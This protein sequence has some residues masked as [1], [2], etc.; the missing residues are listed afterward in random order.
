MKR[1][2]SL[3]DV[4]AVS[5]AALVAAQLL[6]A[7]TAHASCPFPTTD[8]CAEANDGFGHP[9]A[10][11][12]FNND[13][14]EDLAVGVPTEDI[15]SVVDAGAVQ[16]IYGTSGGLASANRQFWSQNSANVEEVA[17]A[18]D[19]FGSSLAAGDFNGDGFDDLAIGV[20][21]ENLGS[22]SNAGLVNVI[23]GSSTG[24]SATFVPDQLWTQD[25]LNIDDAAEAGD[26][27]GDTLA[28]AD[29]NGDGRDDL[30]IGVPQED[31]GSIG[32][33]G[34]ATVIYGSPTGLSSTFIGDQFW[35][36]N[37]PSVDDMAEA[38]DEF[39]F[40]LAAGD[41]NGDGRDDLAVGVP[42]EDISG[43]VSV[44]YGAPT[45]LSS[46]FLSDQI[47]SQDSPDIEDMAESNDFFG[48]N[49]ATG[50]FN[51]DGRDD[52]AIAAEAEMVGTQPDAGA[53]N[54]IYGSPTTG[55]SATF[56][57][58]QFW[59]QDSLNVE[60]DAEFGDHFAVGLTTGDFNGDG[61][62]DLAAGVPQEDIGSV[63]RPGLVN[64]I[65]GSPTG[66]SAT[67][68]ADQLWSQDSANV[69]DANENNDFLGGA[70]V[71][72]DF[73]GDGRDDLAIGGSEDL[74]D[75]AGVIVDAGAVNVIHG[76]SAGLSAT[77]VPDQIWTQI[78][79][80]P[81]QP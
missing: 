63:V 60:E 81:P 15:G 37:S 70:L 2:H 68:V 41:F 76:A 57:P 9:V 38:G 20:P 45:G 73:N 53:V 18:G 28:A 80:V 10:R 55:L 48:S 31:V 77:F 24:L 30:A 11:G 54:V 35:S 46:T 25:S 75:V 7:R 79:I 5:L 52:L 59:S 78:H 33:G 50:D 13:N 58:D 16:V 12:D 34:A 6:A 21:E 17:E 26:L 4:L 72:G 42:G 22:V 32:N 43:A 67:F 61:R 14:F 56:V 40:S 27:L 62:D 23:Y 39:G 69:E 65:Y 29:F 51:G 64:V 47:W 49:L 36:Q 74:Q 19:L 66:L 44:I 1:T 3:P 71:A 8:G